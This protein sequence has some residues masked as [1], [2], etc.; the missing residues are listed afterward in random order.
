M[1][2]GRGCCTAADTGIGD[3]GAI[4]LAAAL[5]KNTTITSIDLGCARA[6]SVC[7]GFEG[8]GAWAHGRSRRARRR[9]MRRERA[10]ARSRAPWAALALPASGPARVQA[11]LRALPLIGDADSGSVTLTLVR[12]R[13]AVLP[14]TTKS[15]MK[16]RQLWRPLSR[17]TG[18]SR[19]STSEVRECARWPA[20]G[21][22]GALGHTAAAAAQAPDAERESALRVLFEW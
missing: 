15:A 2:R 10:L 3:D 4:A 7:R 18:R 11:P 14:Q 21:R 6:C 9:P 12:G 8:W 13:G 20:F 22:V 17:R 5:E 16:A 19:R 1:V